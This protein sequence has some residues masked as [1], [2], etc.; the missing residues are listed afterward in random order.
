MV[1]RLTAE[2]RLA[3]ARNDNRLSSSVDKWLL[4]SSQTD[5]VAASPIQPMETV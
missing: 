2:R 5:E 1:V 3:R 4:L